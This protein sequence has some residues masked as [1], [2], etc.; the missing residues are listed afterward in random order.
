[1]NRARPLSSPTL[2]FAD[3]TVNREN[4]AKGHLLWPGTENTQR[5]VG[6]EIKRCISTGHV[7]LRRDGS[8][9]TWQCLRCRPERLPARQLSEQCLAE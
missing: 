2:R 8:G 7:R 9:T 5:E 1:M 6:E 4:L 3:Y